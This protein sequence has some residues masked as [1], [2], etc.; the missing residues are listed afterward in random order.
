[1]QN[2]RILTY[3]T[4]LIVLLAMVACGGVTPTPAPPT[5]V[6]DNTAV[7]TN[8]P[9]VATTEE[10][11]TDP[12][13]EPDEPTIAPT[14]APTIEPTAEPASVITDADWEPAVIASSPQ[15]GE[16][17]LLDG[18]I[19]LRF[20]QAMDQA[21]VEAAFEV[22]DSDDNVPD[23]VISWPRADTMIFTPASSLDRAQQY[24]V[25]VKETA[26][27]ANGKPLRLGVNLDF[28]TVGYLE[29]SQIVPAA[30]TADV[31]IDSAITVF[32]NRP[33]VPLV[34][35][36]Q[37]ADLPVPIAISPAVEGNGRWL[38]T[39]IYR[40]EPADPMEGAADYTVT[41]ANGLEDITGGV[42]ADDVVSNFRTAAPQVIGFTPSEFYEPVD[43][44]QTIT[45][46]FNMPM[47]RA[48]TESAITISSGDALAFTWAD[49]NRSVGVSAADTLAL[50]L[51]ATLDVAD[52]ALSFNGNAPLRRTDAIQ[53]RTYPFPRVEWT[54]PE[55]DIDNAM[56]GAN[57]R[58][59]TIGFASPM[60]A[61]TLEGSV[62]ISP[63]PGELTYNINNPRSLVVEFD[64]QMEV[65]Y[66][67][68]VSGDVEDIYGNRMGEPYSYT[69][70]MPAAPPLVALNLSNRISQISTAFPS[71]VDILFSDAQSADVALF[72]YGEFGRDNLA[73]PYFEQVPFSENVRTW[74]LQFDEERG[75]QQIELADGG[76]LPTG[77]YGLN[78]DSPQLTD[79]TRY[80]QMNNALLVVADVNLVIK[81]L[82]Q[83]V[84]V[85]ATDME[86]AAPLANQEVTLYYVD[87]QQEPVR[88]I[89]FATVTT[90]ENG[91][92]SADKT[93]LGLIRWENAEFSFPVM[94]T[95]GTAGQPG[96]SIT[97]SSWNSSVETYN[98]SVNADLRDELP[99]MLYLFTDRPLYRPGDTVYVRGLL[100]D[101]N[102]GRYAPAAPRPLTLQMSNWQ[103]E[104]LQI[105]VET[106]ERGLFSSQFVIP[107]DWQTG[108][109]QLGITGANMTGA[110][111]RQITVAEF[112]KPD[113]LVE[114]TAEQTALLR[115]ETVEV[116]VAADYFFGGPAPDL[117]VRWS[118][119][120]IPY[121]LPW[122]KA[123][124]YSFNDDNG[125]YD[126]F[127]GGG[128]SGGFIA[129][130]T[131]KTDA[132]GNVV[133]TLTPEQLSDMP[134]GSRLLNIEATV[135]D[136]G[137][138]AV[139]QNVEVVLHGGEIYA[140]IRTTEYAFPAQSAVE[141]E[142]ITTDWETEIVPDTAVEVIFYERQ[143]VS[144]ASVFD[145]NRI[146]WRPEDTEITR[147][148]VTTNAQGTAT[149]AFT[150]ERG[151]SY[152]AR[153]IVTD[154]AGRTHA[155]QTTLWVY[156]T[157]AVWRTDNK[158]RRLEMIVSADEFNVG[159]EAEILVQAPFAGTAWLTIERGEIIEQRL[160]ELDGNPLSIPITSAYA[161]NV[162]VTIAAVKGVDDSER[163]YADMR[164][165]AVELVVNPAQFKLG[166]A[167][168]TNAET[169]EPRETV[170][171]DLSVTDAD[172]NGVQTELSLAL[173]D[174]ALLSLK[175]DP[176]PPLLDVLYVR[177]PLRSQIGSGL[178][179]SAE[180]LDV[181]I[182]DQPMGG[183]G[184]GGGG[185]MMESAVFSSA[186][187][188]DR[189]K[190]GGDG[191]VRSDFRDTAYWSDI[192]STD[193][194]G[195][196]TVAV[197]LPDNLT[198]W[199]LSIKAVSADT[200]VGDAT[201]DIVVTRKLLVRPLT[202]RFLTVGDQVELGAIIN[203]N[204]GSDREVVVSLA[205]TGVTVNDPTE[206]T[207]TVLDGRETV[208]RWS[209]S[210][211]D[212]D[213]ADFTFTATSGDFRDATKPTVTNGDP[214]PI[215]RFDA[216]DIVATAGVLDD[217]LRRVEA[218]LLPPL[219]NDKKGMLTL[220]LSPS[221]AAAVLDS[222]AAVNQRRDRY[223]MN[224][225]AYWYVE[226]LLPNIATAN[227]IRDLA[228]D[229]TTLLTDLETLIAT[230]IAG[231]R[232]LQRNGGG[233]GF[234]RSSRH[235]NEM[236]SAHALL[237]L[238]RASAAGYDVPARTITNA[239]AYLNIQEV[240][241]ESTWEANRAA[242]FLYVLS[243]VEQDVSGRVDQ[244]LDD[245]RDLL[246]PYAKGLLILADPENDAIN[247]LLNDL[248]TS[249]DVSATGASWENDA[250][251]WNNLNSQ[252]RGTA[253]IIQA[254]LQ[255]D[256][257]N[258]LLPAAVR[259]LMEGRTAQR[260]ASDSDSAWAIMTLAGWMSASAELEADYT[261]NVRV[262]NSLLGDGVFNADNVTDSNTLTIPLGELST[263]G[264]NFFDFNKEG[265][266]RLYY[267]AH[268]DAFIRADSVSAVDRGFS[269][270][271]T[272]YDASCDAES[273]ECEP[274]T[275]ITGGQQVR[276]EL[277]IV[278]PRSQTFVT[279][280]DPLP[281]GADAIDPN[282]D[283]S[284]SDVGV[285]VSYARGYWGW[286]Y[287]NQPQFQDEKVVFTADY[288]PAG[289]Y[290]YT[291]HLQPIIPGEY[292]VMPTIAKAQFR[293]E[294]FG[295]ADGSLFT[296]T[297]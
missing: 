285:G 136:Q 211:L 192:I 49:D 172:G 202:P 170:T 166:I 33:V 26:T 158:D 237:A 24:R 227:A 29:V 104:P 51:D 179:V 13:D 110:A 11:V 212:E 115:G 129:E 132:D 294:V 180:G 240:A 278:V 144:E 154:S 225:C 157:G 151:G 96:Y 183:M 191:E 243:Q 10:T 53:F 15:A 255:A 78:V 52:S 137:N 259:W 252:V 80:W 198:T 88:P 102:Y 174:L 111:Y 20:D 201:D 296:I 264:A 197:P 272:Y 68:T 122:D 215:V 42:L 30:D 204:T 31:A 251:D 261:Y 147:E 293:P 39:S 146:S 93:Y 41:V 217:D 47:D 22:V 238:G 14:I 246:D 177:Q 131:S 148:T 75:A 292:Q 282:L 193:A 61:D 69:F 230:D 40:F 182:P 97:M 273:E 213:E 73:Y 140:G 271:R 286:W 279:I 195:Q 178:F 281:S 224:D 81:E 46:T 54:Y 218:V 138:I 253:I 17:A 48:S 89:P 103:G 127:F 98:F 176:T 247:T 128:D 206:Q 125:Y 181:A 265:D 8:T 72:S 34:S 287:F 235:A 58:G 269:V 262:N 91:F 169:F 222:L 12:T 216:E 242:F 234:C 67:V 155:S 186:E 165:G 7:P 291:Y 233:W 60:N 194:N 79:D 210:V 94:A 92:A 113:V 35:T 297:E 120:Y 156:G 119:S 270:Q 284:G 175:E 139:S 82:P 114:M 9:I 64:A 214:L 70:L 23:G 220:D 184:G 208:V 27:A 101:N 239:I 274:I 260:W 2:N 112:R 45:V 1:M 65:R 126:P 56:E 171:Y 205:A 25:R 74:S 107:D 87:E 32:F 123:P 276:V 44:K 55:R 267:T 241:V 43:P 149:A 228:L 100:R 121:F 3:V 275:S 209:V 84:V 130:G 168:S 59:T 258:P 85:W 142:V 83:R 124:Y 150:P 63:D 257:D 231:L 134:A 249:A 95:T 187:S 167:V 77:V 162:F 295:R 221:L 283:T 229:K 116:T 117:D 36:G 244:L 105:A 254:L 263:E 118:A 163:P 250:L 200:R 38:S 99:Q 185:G 173:V 226:Q 207:V 290:Q 19:T 164:Y 277:T 153:A 57:F 143:W 106:D 161:P 196:A 160:I 223:S 189:S 188:D 108:V 199:Q 28:E 232:D 219:L 50:D 190:S 248:N 135:T 16:E 133:I 71:T 236:I 37:Q 152:V 266:G 280:E 109:Q 86:T 66:T 5:A 62:T 21:S 90:D 268:M 141:V 6:P 288:L 203:N 4:L 159:D 18:A 76:T 145:A 245:G 289:T 256:A